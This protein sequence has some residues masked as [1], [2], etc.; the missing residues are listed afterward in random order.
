MKVRVMQI[1][2]VE[3]AIKS[4]SHSSIVL[5]DEEEALGVEYA[6]DL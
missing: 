1:I 5:K 6:R 4:Q 2:Q 3:I